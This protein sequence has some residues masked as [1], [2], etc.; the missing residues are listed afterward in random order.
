MPTG[1]RTGQSIPLTRRFNKAEAYNAAFQRQTAKLQKSYTGHCIFKGQFSLF[2]YAAAIHMPKNTTDSLL[3]GCPLCRVPG[4]GCFIAQ[5]AHIR[6]Y[7]PF[8]THTQ[9]RHTVY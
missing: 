5:T 1:S 7:L 9:N 8:L 6:R 3:Y 4:H 2:L